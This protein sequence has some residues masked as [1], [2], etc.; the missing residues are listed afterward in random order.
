MSLSGAKSLCN[1]A[2][3]DSQTGF[4]ATGIGWLAGCVEGNIFLF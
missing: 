1:Y 4:K 3:H 2:E